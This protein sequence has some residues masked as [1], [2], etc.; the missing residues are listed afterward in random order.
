[1]E[2]FLRAA[3]VLR[4]HQQVYTNAFLMIGLPAG[5]YGKQTEIEQGLQLA[6]SSFEEAFASI[7]PNSV[8]SQVQ[9]TG[10]WFYMN[11]HL[12]FHRLFTEERAGK[13]EQQFSHLGALSDIISPEIGF[14]PY[15]HGYLQNKVY[16]GTD[17]RTVERL[18]QRLATSD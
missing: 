2:T 16:G 11:Y 8:P 13:I 15:F 12:N 5:A 7:P 4:K 1:M 10:I 17:A 3:E 9:L 14:A 6:S 18:K